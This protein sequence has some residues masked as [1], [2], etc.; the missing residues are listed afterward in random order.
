MSADDPDDEVIP[1]VPVTPRTK[2]GDLWILGDHR[3]GCGDGRDA[4]FL[5]RVIGYGACVDAAF[6]DPPYNVPVGGHAG[7]AGRPR[8]F[9]IGS[10]EMSEAA[11]RSFL[12][13]EGQA[14]GACRRCDLG[15]AATRRSRARSLPGI[16]N[17]AYG[18]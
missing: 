14:D 5:R 8:E 11:V 3:V 15:C 10:G 1:Q 6:L 12:A 17:H 7:S 16:G 4:E 9:A 18:S 13:A 2:L